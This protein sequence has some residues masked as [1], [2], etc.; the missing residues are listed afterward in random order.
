MRQSSGAMRRTV[1]GG[2]LPGYGGRDR[3]HGRV[4]EAQVRGRLDEAR[5]THRELDR[6]IAA[7][8]EQGVADQIGIARLKKRKLMLRDEIALLEDRLIP[9]IIA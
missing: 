6:A 1:G 3:G 9:D 2:V 4:D 8:N 5:S 7:L